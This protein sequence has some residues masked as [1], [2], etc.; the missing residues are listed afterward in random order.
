VNDKTE[1]SH[2][3]SPGRLVLIRTAV[4]SWSG[5]VLRTLLIEGAPFVE[6][7]EAAWVADT[8]RYHEALLGGVA[9]AESSEIEPAPKGAVVL[10]A[11]AAI[12]D[13]APLPVVPTE[14]R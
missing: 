9:S 6:L 8:G 2:L 5:R 10:V 14:V 7:A 13:V 4:H 1:S 12:G 11:I 3:L